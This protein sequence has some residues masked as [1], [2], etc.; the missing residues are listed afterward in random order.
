MIALLFITFFLGA[1]GSCNGT[2]SGQCGVSYGTCTGGRTAGREACYCLMYYAKC[3]IKSGCFSN[4][5]FTRRCLILGC[6][7]F[8][9]PNDPDYCFWLSSGSTKQI[10][11]FILIL[12][13]ILLFTVIV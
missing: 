7:N 5:S 13:L 12:E 3:E 9:D 11:Y 4:E 2:Q 8:K 6:Q 1:Y 10:S